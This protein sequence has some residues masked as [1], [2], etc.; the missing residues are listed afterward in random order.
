MML[1]PISRKTVYLLEWV[2]GLNKGVS[3]MPAPLVARCEP[4]GNQDK[5]TKGD[6]YFEHKT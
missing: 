5:V 4:G 2:P 3:Q 6:I 1:I